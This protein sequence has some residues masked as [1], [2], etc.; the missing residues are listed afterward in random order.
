L[1]GL[2]SCFDEKIIEQDKLVLIY[3][4]LLIAQDTVTLDDR[5]VDSLK[6]SVFKKYNV[7]EK[8]YENT[9]EY[10]ND[11]LK[12]WEEFFDKVTAHIGSL[13]TKAD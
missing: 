5:G 10:Y 6:Q 9:I 8:E 4:D 3:T 7:T 13:N 1:I 11:D 12:R 2:Y